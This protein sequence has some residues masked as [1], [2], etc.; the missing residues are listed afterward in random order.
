MGRVSI[1][2]GHP[3][4]TRRSQPMPRCYTE[5]IAT[6]GGELDGVDFHSADARLV[7]QT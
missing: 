4:P 6:L 5:A 1:P 7:Q 2:K 3:L